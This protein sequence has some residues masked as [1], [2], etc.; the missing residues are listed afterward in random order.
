VLPRGRIDP[1]VVAIGA[2]WVVVLA[3]AGLRLLEIGP[4]TLPAFDSYAYWA[5]RDG[6]DYATAVQGATGAYLYSPAFAQA[7][8]PLTALPWPA[9]AALWTVLI[10]ATLPILVGRLA[11]LVLVVPLVAMSVALGQ[12]DLPIAIAAVVGLRW[13]AAWA[14]PILTKVTPAVG[15]VWF[16][17]RRE[18][19]S[20]GVA[21]LVTG[22]IALVSAALDPAGWREWL[23]LLARARF[24][25]L[26]GDLWFLPIPLLVRLPVAAVLVGWGAATGRRW[27]VPVGVFL[28]LPTIWLNA[29]TILLAL[30][31]V[32][33]PTARPLG[34]RL[35]LGRLA[36]G[37]RPE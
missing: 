25:E 14:L 16:L 28:A 34:G 2:Y 18:W 15:L 17:V 4:W 22:G 33:A 8:A 20:L 24:P 32:L 6:L 21:V 30:V 13:P 3:F 23:A 5:T 27:V 11:I 7:I 36:A 26:G 35:P 1:G 12:L 19:R 10:A 37:D 9:F 31:P 29:P